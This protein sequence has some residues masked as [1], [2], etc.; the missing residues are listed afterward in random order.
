MSHLIC[1]ISEILC[2]AKNVQFYASVIRTDIDITFSSLHAMH[3]YHTYVLIFKTSGK[4]HT[5]S[6]IMPHII[7]STNQ[8]GTG[9]FYGRCRRIN[10]AGKFE[11]NKIRVLEG[12]LVPNCT[13][14]RL[15]KN[16]LHSTR[17][18]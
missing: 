2:Q 11:S 9:Y 7:Y 3:T 18:I 5:S 10:V 14:S 4:F 16:A 1:C 15:Y 17:G 13:V 6:P 8:H 12:T